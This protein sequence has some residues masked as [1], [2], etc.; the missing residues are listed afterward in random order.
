MHPESTETQTILN[1]G[2][3]SLPRSYQFISFYIHYC[4]IECI[5]CIVVVISNRVFFIRLALIYGIFAC[6]ENVMCYQRVPLCGY[7][8]YLVVCSN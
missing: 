6:G 2:L 8:A 1:H 5:N 4:Y 7:P 3:V